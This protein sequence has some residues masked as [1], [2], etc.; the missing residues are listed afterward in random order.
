MKVRVILNWLILLLTC[1]SIWIRFACF[2]NHG[3]S[4]NKFKG[5]LASCLEGIVA[6]LVG[7]GAWLGPL[8]FTMICYWCLSC[9]HQENPDPVRISIRAPLHISHTKVPGI[10]VAWVPRRHQKGKTSCYSSPY[11]TSHSSSFGTR[12]QRTWEN[13]GSFW[14]EGVGV[15]SERVRK[16]T[17]NLAGTQPSSGKLDNNK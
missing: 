14:P 1:V 13:Q 10:P 17:F 2:A 7:W 16:E 11:P 6:L 5:F 4:T 12:P 9:S 15:G 3:S 8:D